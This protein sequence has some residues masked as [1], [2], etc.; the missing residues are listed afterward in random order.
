MRAVEVTSCFRS[1]LRNELYVRGCINFPSYRI[2]EDTRPEK[3]ARNGESMRI[4]RNLTK[5]RQLAPRCS[6]PRFAVNLS[7][8]YE[9]IAQFHNITS[10][11]RLTQD[12]T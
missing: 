2:W 1:P 6:Q 12:E 7:A 8:D 3:T 10:T 4:F 5:R 11:H 9:K